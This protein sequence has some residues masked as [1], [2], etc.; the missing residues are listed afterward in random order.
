MKRA[1][2]IHPFSLALITLINNAAMKTSGCAFRFKVSPDHTST[3]SLLRCSYTLAGIW[4]TV[5][6]RPCQSV[7][8]L[9]CLFKLSFLVSRSCKCC[10]RL[11]GKTLAR[12]QNPLKDVF[13]GQET[14]TPESSIVFFLQ[15]LK[16]STEPVTQPFIHFCGNTGCYF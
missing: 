11:A 16:G 7:S 5:M 4:K 6:I 9:S 13:G 1:E 12:S 15:T 14:F 2:S 3:C 8:L 10:R